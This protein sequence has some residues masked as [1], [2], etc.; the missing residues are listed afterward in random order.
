MISLMN[1]LSLVVAV[2]LSLPAL[3]FAQDPLL[4][5]SRYVEREG[6]AAEVPAQPPHLPP[7]VIRKM[8]EVMNKVD[9]HAVDSITPEQWD[10]ASN[11]ALKT[12]LEQLH[13]PHSYYQDP[14]QWADRQ[15][16][17]G[18]QGFSGIGLQVE[19]DP[20]GEGVIGTPMPTQPAEKAG[21][22]AGD[23]VTAVDGVSLK[24]LSLDAAVSKIRGPEGTPVTLTVTRKGVAQPLRITVVRGT[25]V[26]KQTFAKLVAPGIGYVYLT[27]FGDPGVTD[28][29]VFARIDALRRQGARKLIFDLRFNPG[30]NVATVESIV[31][32]FLTDGQRIVTFKRQ[33]QIENYADAQGQG[34]YATMPLVV[35]VNGM[36]AS[37]SEIMSGS[38]QDHHR[39]LIVGQ[40]SFGKGSAQTILPIETDGGMAI[41]GITSSKWFLPAGRAIQGQIDPKTDLEIAGTGGVVP[42]HEVPS[43]EEQNK[44]L[45]KSLRDQLVGRPAS[46]QDAALDKAVELLQ[47]PRS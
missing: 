8:N 22:L 6:P 16:E 36:S 3:S 33:G 43:S 39:A 45:L 31:S 42:D 13:I 18:E 35:L 21:L 1:S 47:K 14:K 10:K 9:R 41:V 7:S 38:L 40:R 11:E 30:G 32:E 26:T 34:R 46:G 20:K 29:E 27:E 37:A 5:P 19:L 12:L 4:V 15:S 17:A 2:S 25:I 24:G 44:A 28:R 23:L